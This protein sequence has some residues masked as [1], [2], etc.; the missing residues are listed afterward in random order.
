MKLAKK[1][2]PLR[3]A[4]IAPLWVRVPPESYGGIERVVHILTEELVRRGHEV[5]LFAAGNSQTSAKLR[6]VCECSMVE[7]MEKGEAY[8]Y[9]YYITSSLVEALRKSDSFDLI[10]CHVGC[11]HIPLAMLSKK[12]VLYTIRTM[13][14]VDDQWVLKY[15]PQVPISA[16]SQSQIMHIPHEYRKNIRVI[17]NGLDFDACEYSIAPGKYL[18]FLGR[19]GPVK[20]PL[21]AIL[22]AKTVGLPIVLAGRAEDLE[23]K[24]Y[25][26]EKIEPLIDG[27][28]VAYLGMVDQMQKNEFLKNAAALLFPIQWEE[29]F[30]NV[31][32]EAMACGTPVVA[33]QRG[34]VSEVVDFGKTGFYAESLE[35]LIPFVSKALS[36]DRKMVRDHARKRFSYQKMVDEYLEWYRSLLRSKVLK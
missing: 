6:A 27:K 34:S 28:H 7:L 9:E 29:P 14:N 22:I 18:A 12:P 35:A 4:Q 23:E 1:L 31:M 3:I 33:Y 26:R 10:H 21:D 36:L 2:S 30:G 8:N 11:H 17:Y 15:Y 20:N 24:A 5:S 25:F 13:V 16:I 32:I 19:M